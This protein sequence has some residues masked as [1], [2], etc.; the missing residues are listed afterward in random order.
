MAIPNAPTLASL[1]NEGLEKAGI[2][3]EA[4]ASVVMRARNEWVEEI[5]ADIWEYAKKLIFLQTENIQITVNGQNKYSMPTD[6]SSNLSIVL[7]H[8]GRIGTAQAGGSATITLASTE[9]VT[10]ESIRGKEI[11]IY[12]GTGINELKQC[13]SYNST[14]KVATVTSAWTTPP[15]G[16]SSYMIIDI[17]IPLIQNPIMRFDEINSMPTGEP[18]HYFPIGDADNGEFLL[19]PTPY[20]SDAPYGI[21]QRYYADLTRLDLN[22]TLLATLYRRWRNVFLAGIYAKALENKDAPNVL[23]AKANYQKALLMLQMREQYGMDLNELTMTIH[24]Y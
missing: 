10:E 21:K 12:A 11:L 22:G 7:M 17:Y 13:I 3:P 23:S 14:T 8:G 4:F 9:T 18:T 19:Y 2:N 1:V 5:K 16:T 20:Q 24:D 6:F 15:N